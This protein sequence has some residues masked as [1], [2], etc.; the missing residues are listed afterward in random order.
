MFGYVT[1]YL[2]DKP[3]L[4]KEVLEKISLALCGEAEN[5]GFLRRVIDTFLLAGFEA[6]LGAASKL[7][8]F[9]KRCL[10]G[11]PYLY[12]RILAKPKRNGL[13]VSQHR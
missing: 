9:I 11:G 6:L 3:N 4:G 8:C 12:C 5:T 10:T 2:E 1:F 13:L 7:A